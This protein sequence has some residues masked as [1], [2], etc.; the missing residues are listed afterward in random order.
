MSF[1]ADPAG[2]NNHSQTS[3]PQGAPGFNHDGL[4]QLGRYLQEV[5]YHHITVTPLTHRHN[6][7][8]PRNRQARNLRDV[9]GWSRPFAQDAVSEREFKLMRDAGILMRQE[10]H[11][12][13]QVRWASLHGLLCVHSAFPTDAEDAVFFGP[14]TYRFARV[15]QNYLQHRPHTERPLKRAADIGCGSGAGALLIASACPAA[16]IF[17]I[18]INP[19]ALQMTAVNAEL[20]RADNIEPLYSDL[21][22]RLEGEVDLVVANPPYMLDAQRRAYRHGGGELGEEISRQI[23]ASALDRL[24]RGGTLLLY[25]G[26]AIVDGQDPFLAGLKHQLVDQP[27][28][29]TYEEIDPDVFS[30][31]LTKPAY[32]QVERIAAVCL[33][34]TK[35]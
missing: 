10:D 28:R 30:D 29:W 11:W 24:A 25:T 1:Y 19:R 6:N 9:F 12:R 7:E 15:I 21:L 4:V 14:D 34:L 23:V 3:E 33:T 8:S 32:A 16:H 13:S 26:V 35:A 31:E 18:D 5:G 20:A 2:A 27:C 17:A 22:S